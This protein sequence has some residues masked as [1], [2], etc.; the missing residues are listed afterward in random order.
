VQIAL[1]LL[2]TREGVLLDERDQDKPVPMR[3]PERP[4]D[5]DEPVDGLGR[6]PAGKLADAPRR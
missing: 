4:V 6:R 2:E 1:L 5:V 3:R